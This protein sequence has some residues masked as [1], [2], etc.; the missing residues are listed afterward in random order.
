MSSLANSGR[1]E[2][3]GRH[4]WR[5][6]RRSGP[7]LAI[8][9]RGR[10]RN[11]LAERGDLRATDRACRTGP[12]PATTMTR[13][14]R[15]RST[16]EPPA[17]QAQPAGDRPQR[18]MATPERGTE[19]PTASAATM[20]TEAMIHGRTPVAAGTSVREYTVPA[21]TVSS[22]TSREA[23][24]CR[25]RHAVAA[26]RPHRAARAGTNAA[27]VVGVEVP[28]LAEEAQVSIGQPDHKSVAARRASVR[29]RRRRETSRAA[30]AT[31]EGTTNQ[32]S[33]RPNGPCR[34]RPH[35]GAMEAVPRPS[36]APTSAVSTRKCVGGLHPC[37]CTRVAAKRSSPL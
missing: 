3:V 12:A 1:L 33:S 13:L 26:P 24:A 34:S 27:E 35:P 15:R 21:T 20:T 7:A 8:L 25:H 10:S 9:R 37:W 32:A 30:A 5:R 31:T 29:G 14:P 11:A 17:G 19:D 18:G 23:T 6:H 28:P 36:D 16:P 22:T 4:R 2:D